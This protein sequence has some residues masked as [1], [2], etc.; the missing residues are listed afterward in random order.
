MLKVKAPVFQKMTVFGDKAFKEVIV[1]MK[2]CGWALA[3]VT[4]V[5]IGKGNLDTHR[6]TKD[7]CEHRKD[8]ARAKQE[9][10]HLQVNHR[11]LRGN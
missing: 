5:F 8:H 6:N 9:G 7:A 3:H 11:G 4:G 10:S 1:K 2:L